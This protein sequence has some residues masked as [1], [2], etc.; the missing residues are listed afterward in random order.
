MKYTDEQMEKA[1]EIGIFTD[2]QVKK[3]RDYIQNSSNQVT[4]L[5][6]VLYYGGGL[7]IISALTWLM[8][9]NWKRFGP[10]VITFFSAIYLLV[11]LFVRRV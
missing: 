5:Q 1:V 3:L 11:F 2:D 4:K 10:G 8:I 6:K 7:L 9:D